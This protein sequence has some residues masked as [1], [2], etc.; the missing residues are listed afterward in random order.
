MIKRP[1]IRLHYGALHDDII[2]DGTVFVRHRL[3]KP[4]RTF[5][6][7]TIVGVLFPEVSR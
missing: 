6:R 1:D 4:E 2:V 7:K 5:V 3:T